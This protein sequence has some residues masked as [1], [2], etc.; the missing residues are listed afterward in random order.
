MLAAGYAV[1]VEP[2]PP[3]PEKTGLFRTGGPAS[4]PAVARYAAIMRTA[5]TLILI[6]LLAR[7]RRQPTGQLILANVNQGRK[8][9]G[10]R[11]G[12]V[13]RLLVLEQLPS[14]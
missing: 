14:R 13:R 11:P 9:A 1:G 2:D 12:E 6:F 5:A 3:I 8:M 10:V 4:T 7:D